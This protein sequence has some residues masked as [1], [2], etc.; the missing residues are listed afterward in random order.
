MNETF[1]GD[2]KGITQ[3]VAPTMS[4]VLVSKQSKLPV[5]DKG[6]NSM[7]TSE[8]N[9]RPQTRGKNTTILSINSQSK[10]AKHFK[11]RGSVGEVRNGF[12]NMFAPLNNTSEDYQLSRD[13]I[14]LDSSKV[15]EKQKTTVRV[16]EAASV[17]KH[18][19]P[20]E[21]GSIIINAT[22]GGDKKFLP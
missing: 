12:E 4:K 22:F 13:Q 10:L 20:E 15:K 16:R 6:L 2:P 1:R 7:P 9:S 5:K 3:Q 11:S 14:K 18:Q 8:T 21:K 19:P 17:D